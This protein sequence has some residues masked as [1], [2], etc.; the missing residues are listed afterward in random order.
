MVR[1]EVL[2]ID[3]TDPE[4]LFYTVRLDG[5]ERHTTE[6]RLTSADEAQRKRAATVDLTRASETVV[7]DDDDDDDEPPQIRPAKAARLSPQPHKPVHRAPR[8]RCKL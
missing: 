2:S 4:E 6:A 1:V 7:L 3:Y 8:W 5:A